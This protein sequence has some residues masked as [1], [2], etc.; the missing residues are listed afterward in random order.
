MRRGGSLPRHLDVPV[1]SP[2]NDAW[3]Q[4]GL[5]QKRPGESSPAF[6]ATTATRL[7][8]LILDSLNAT[9]FRTTGSY[10]LSLSFSVL[11]RGF[12]SSRRSSPY[13]RS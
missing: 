4:T 3:S 12:S 9:C 7:V 10:F 2:L 6:F 5:T 1:L 8:Y 11:A 13:P